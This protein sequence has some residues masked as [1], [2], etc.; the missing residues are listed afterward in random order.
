M[1]ESL[2][3]GTP[4]FI[5]VIYSVRYSASL[6]SAGFVGAILYYFEACG[7]RAISSYSPHSCPLR[8]PVLSPAL[9]A[10]WKATVSP[11]SYF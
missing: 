10:I 11:A 6:S 5:G 4:N 9:W 7:F 2:E 3:E 8:V 1:R